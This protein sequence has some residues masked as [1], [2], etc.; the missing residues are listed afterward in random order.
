MGGAP[1]RA[2][3]ASA[4]CVQ[5]PSSGWRTVSTVKP[6][7]PARVTHSSTADEW[8]SCST[9]TR[10][11]RGTLNIFAAVETPYPTDERQRHVGRIGLDQSRRGLARAL[12]LLRG[13]FVIEQPRLPLALHRRAR[14]L[15]RPQWQR[16]IR[17]GVEVTDLARD[18][19]ECALAGEHW[20]L[21]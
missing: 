7:S 11:P 4:A 19:E 3:A 10:A 18:I 1:W 14:R 16:A 5:S 21:S 12:V 15:L 17:R 2:M 9:K 20:H 6:P 8:S 13:E